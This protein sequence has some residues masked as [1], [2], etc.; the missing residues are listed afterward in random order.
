LFC[1]VRDV[2]GLLAGLCVTALGHAAGINTAFDGIW[3]PRLLYNNITE[4]HFFFVILVVKND[5]I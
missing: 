4:K 2:F 5:V 3:K 1:C